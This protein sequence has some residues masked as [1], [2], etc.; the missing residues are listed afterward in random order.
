MDG[1][2]DLRWSLFDGRDGVLGRWRDEAEVRRL[3]AHFHLLE[4]M[5]RG[6]WRIRCCCCCYL[7]GQG[8]EP[9]VKWVR[10]SMNGTHGPQARRRPRFE[11]S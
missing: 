1:R 6:R 3:G 8:D 10:T 7:A 2:G 11:C 4:G 9:R 5:I